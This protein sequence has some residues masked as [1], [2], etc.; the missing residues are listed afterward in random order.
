MARVSIVLE[1]R[2]IHTRDGETFDN[3]QA[4]YA[5]WKRYLAAFEEVQV[6]GRSTLV[7]RVPEGYRPVQGPGV[8]VL[9]VPFYQGPVGLL[10]RLPA[11]TA[12]L[13]RGV[14]PEDA[15]IVRLSGVLGHLAAG[16]RQLARQP[17]AVEVVN[18]PFMG[19]GPDGTRQPLRPLFR[20]LLTILTRLQCKQAVAV[21]Y[22]TRQALQQRYPPRSAAQSFSVS[23]VHLPPE[24]YREGPRQYT[25]PAR[26]A[27]LVGTLE[28]R[29][30]AADIALAALGRLRQEGHDLRLR[31]V[32]DGPLRPELER[33]ARELGIKDAVEFAGQRSTPAAVRDDLRE[34]E[35]FLIPSRTEGMPRAL[36]EALAQ[37][38]P[39]VGSDVGGIPEVIEGR[40]LVRPGDV[41]SLVNAWRS[42][43]LD[44]LALTE[45]S[46]VNWHEA[47]TYADS[48][49]D[50]RRLAFY[51][52]VRQASTR[53]NK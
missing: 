22:V 4:T 34:A 31:I 1:Q 30:K 37:A 21:Q 42:L 28:Q 45:Q 23:D 40:Y 47:A 20:P 10:R 51:R 36:L 6:V 38:L 11:V 43:A 9:H 3:G 12:T 50:E 8:R 27:V 29:H 2:F 19:Y 26:L 48:V 32:G 33:Q 13:Q 53:R 7:D 41:D 44:P 17:F 18:D 52:A 49:L 46:S 24:A 5:H 14:P 39:A 16:L 25:Q 35:L 15:V